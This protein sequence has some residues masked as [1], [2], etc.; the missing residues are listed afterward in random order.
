MAAAAVRRERVAEAPTAPGVA[1]G[2]WRF[3]PAALWSAALGFAYVCLTTWWVL[4]DHAIPGGGD[5]GIH[6]NTASNAGDLLADFDIGGL[7]DLGPVGTEFFYPPLVHV[8]GG[9]PAALGLAVQDWGTIA[10]NIVFVPMLVAGVYLSG[11]RIYGPTA[12]LLAVLFALCTP[13]TL[14]LFHVF[15]LDAPLAG[16]VALTVAA[17]LYS[18]RFARRLPSVLAGG[19]VGVCMLVKPSAPL[20]LIGPVLVMLVAGGWRQWRRL[21]LAAVALA[22]VA[23]PYYAIHLDDV[24]D[25]GQASTVGTEIGRTGTEFDRDARISYDNLSW[26]GWAA[27]NQVY[28]VPLL[29]LFAGGV[30]V[31]VRRWRQPGVA[32]L[33]AGAV[34][35]YLALALVLSIRDPR[36]ALPTVV[37]V[38]V[39]GAGWITTISAAIWRRV[40]LGLLGLIAAVNV[41]ASVI[42]IPNVRVLAPNST[43]E[44]DND[45]ATFT[46]FTDRGYFVGPPVAN[47]LWTRLFD[48][49]E[50]EGL[51]SARLKIRTTGL[52]SLDPVVFDVV[53]RQA[54]VRET[55][56]TAE[57]GTKPELI[58][59]TWFVGSRFPGL[60][61]LLPACGAIDD[62]IS[63]YGEPLLTNVAVRRLQ[64]DGSYE[65]WC[66]F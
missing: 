60:R 10:V 28:Y 62:G 15:V 9:I 11:K 55:S 52:W 23:G 31:A 49:A 24:L 21:L 43:F 13:M 47:D 45:P 17:L 26:Y 39:I 3:E 46:F 18:D 32:E 63:W 54:G 56:L 20:Y 53:S 22:V 4:R 5:P 2:R 14:S 25:L 41:V 57:P 8:I 16:A 1:I 38:A 42:S 27:I 40:L 48:A 33:L 64:P 59:D 37:F 44:L 65:P 34:V 51:T 7:I 66:D 61:K 12:G 36:Y 19:L 58:V 6:L 35:T 29:A 50:E 30:V